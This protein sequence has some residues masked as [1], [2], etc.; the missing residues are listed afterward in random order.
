[1]A[2][3]RE[4][5]GLLTAC[6]GLSEAIL[7]ELRVLQQPLV[8]LPLAVWCQA[9]RTTTTYCFPGHGNRWVCGQRATEAAA[10]L[11]SFVSANH[12]SLLVGMG[13][14]STQFWLAVLRCISPSLPQRHDVQQAH[15]R[16]RHQRLALR[17][18]WLDT[19]TLAFHSLP[20]LAQHMV[21]GPALP[22]CHADLMQLSGDDLQQARQL[23]Q[24]FLPVDEERAWLLRYLG[25][26]LCPADGSKQLLVLTDSLEAAPGNAGKSA[27]LGWLAA[28][29]GPCKC[30]V[31]S[32]QALTV[33]RSHSLAAPGGVAAPLLRVFDEITRSAGKAAAH[34]L[35]IGTL[36]Y[37]TAGRPGGPAV[38]IA[39]NLGDLPDLH[40][41][42]QTDPSFARRLVL[43]PARARF[44]GSAGGNIHSQLENTARA[45]ARILL[46]EFVQVRHAGCELL[47]VTD[48][49]QQF[50]QLAVRAT[51]LAGW[52]PHI[53]QAARQWVAVHLL[54][55]PNSSMP[56]PVVQQ[57]FVG[58]VCA[59]HNSRCGQLDLGQLLDAVLASHGVQVTAGLYHGIGW[60]S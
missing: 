42:Q 39:A 21:F 45:L 37:L 18:G 13:T 14:T 43:L 24:S 48:S 54:L 58:S 12:S 55:Q 9:G 20:Y 15:D 30:P 27:L 40:Q 22:H 2:A 5:L 11:E 52:Q 56:V 33:A 34:Q 29:L 60:S 28:A 36:K 7:T 23:L 1:M 6:R 46:D 47:P 3:K 26:C 57:L 59:P 19:A 32:G 31:N 16:V 4:H 10:F 53:V 49:M 38:V 50:K 41:L 35:D 8:N 44:D 25:R 17:D 51:A